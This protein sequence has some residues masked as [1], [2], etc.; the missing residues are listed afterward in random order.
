MIVVTDGSRILGLGDLGVQGIGIPIGKLDMYVAAAGINPQRVC[1]TSLYLHMP[2][3]FGGLGVG[4]R[5]CAYCACMRH[6]CTSSSGTWMFL[7]DFHN[8]Y[9]SIFSLFI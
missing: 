4:G 8:I 9:A 7:Q 6:A 5:V 2:L 3:Y 1:C